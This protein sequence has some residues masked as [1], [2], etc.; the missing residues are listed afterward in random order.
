[1]A[2]EPVVLDDP[3]RAAFEESGDADVYARAQAGFLEGFLAPSF[4]AAI[5]GDRPEA[6]E[7]VWSAAR[8]RIATDPLAVSPRYRLVTAL[9]CR[10]A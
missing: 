10:V 5:G 7:A 4:A 6:L 3:F 8:R 9:F 2:L 1:V